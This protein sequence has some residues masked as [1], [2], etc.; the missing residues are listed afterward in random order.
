ML[1]DEGV[2]AYYGMVVAFNNYPMFVESLGFQIIDQCIAYFWRKL[3]LLTVVESRKARV[4]QALGLRLKSCCLIHMD[5]LN[6]I[7]TEQGITTFGSYTGTWRQSTATEL[8]QFFSKGKLNFN[9]YLMNFLCSMSNENNLPVFQLADNLE[10]EEISSLHW[11]TEWFFIQVIISN[12]PLFLSCQ[13]FIIT[14]I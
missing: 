4:I 11:Y 9:L 7:S 12:C 2:I 1:D 13:Y 3:S 10:M 14:G 8:G 5:M 6:H